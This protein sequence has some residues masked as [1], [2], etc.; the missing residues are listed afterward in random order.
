[1]SLLTEMLDFDPKKRITAADALNHDF[2]KD[3]GFLF[4]NSLDMCIAANNHEN[5]IK[6]LLDPTIK[7]DEI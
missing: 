4:K 6:D 7:M 5:Y 3:R 1:M 2:F